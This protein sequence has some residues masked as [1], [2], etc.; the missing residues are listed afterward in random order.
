EQVSRLPVDTEGGE[1]N[2]E[3][4][5][6]VTVVLGRE[7]TQ[8]LVQEVPQVYHTQINDV[9]LTALGQALGK[10][11]GEEKVLVDLEGHGREDIFDG[12][13]LSRTVGW[14]T[15][16]YPVALD[17]PGEPDLGHALMAV[18][19]QIRAVPGRGLGYGALRYLTGTAPAVDAPV[20]FNYLGQFVRPTGGGLVRAGGGIEGDVA[21]DEA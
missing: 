15:T 2:R 7:Q 9:L 6:T 21:A 8:A 4:L 17:L 11:S 10:W 13:D 3:S 14:F 19:E 16:M 5:G 12:V 18:K 20:S 1:N